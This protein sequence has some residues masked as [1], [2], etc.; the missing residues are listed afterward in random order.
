[1]KTNINVNVN[2]EAIVKNAVNTSTNSDFI[3]ANIPLQYL[4]RAS[5]QRIRL[6]KTNVRKIAKNWNWNQFDLLKVT[7][8]YNNDYVE[9]QDG[10]H[11]TNAAI[12][13]NEE[14][15]Q[16]IQTLPCRIFI[17]LSRQEE[18]NIF[19][20]QQENITRL[21]IVD[22]F[23]SLIE[24]GDKVTI[25]FVE[26][27]NERNILISGY[28]DGIV[29]GNRKIGSIARAKDIIQKYGKDCLSWCFDIIF[30]ARWDK[31]Q[32]GFGGSILMSL[33]DFYKNPVRDLI[34][35]NL[36]EILKDVKNVHTL[37]IVSGA[38][39]RGNESAYKDYFLSRLNNEQ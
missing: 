3:I 35:F 27:C 10:W 12:L 8:H 29:H 7:Y 21:R 26:L 38:G 33:A 14:Y 18:L 13:A 19:L 15:G 39:N 1:M 34:K 37:N 11:R 30:A 5:N 31:T 23:P 17:N 36:I 16:N 2:L 24:M 20:K 25:D 9:V 28:N 22:K 4:H 32:G 6:N